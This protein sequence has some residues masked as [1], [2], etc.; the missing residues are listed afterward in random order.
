MANELADPRLG[1]L[2][3][4]LPEQFKFL[5][6]FVRDKQHGDQEP[7]NVAL[8]TKNLL[9]DWL[10]Y[11]GQGAASRQGTGYTD[12]PPE[13]DMQEIR[14]TGVY[15]N[16]FI[17]NEFSAYGYTD[18]NTTTTTS[19]V[20]NPAYQRYYYN[21]DI[22]F[23]EL[24]SLSDSGLFKQNNGT[25]PRFQKF[26]AVDNIG[27]EEIVDNPQ[28]TDSNNNLVNQPPQFI[29]ELWPLF[30]YALAVN[31][32]QQVVNYD[33]IYPKFGFDEE[34]SSSLAP[35]KT[36]YQQ[37]YN[38]SYE[39]VQFGYSERWLQNGLKNIDQPRESY[40][41]RD[42]TVF[43]RDG[44]ITM[45]EMFNNFNLLLPGSAGSS[46]SVPTGRS[47]GWNAGDSTAGFPGSGFTTN[48]ANLVSEPMYELVEL[49]SPNQTYECYQNVLMNTQYPYRS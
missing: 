27:W 12:R 24:S 36:G 22:R 5:P 16:Q 39:E 34:S 33:Q 9:P 11:P 40:W 29:L 31:P 49:P 10:P 18:V 23:E 42:S 41:D 25:I 44:L 21:V 38:P 48:G 1:A 17:D 30:T 8:I 45:F 2:D 14:R 26:G 32:N 3:F 7:G 43:E 4:T 6:L 15:S 47:F 28:E 35:S 37:L 19:R 20:E 13:Y 46:F